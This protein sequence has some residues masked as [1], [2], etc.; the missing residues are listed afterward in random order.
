MTKRLKEHQ[1]QNTFNSNETPMF[2]GK[3]P[4]TDWNTLE[5]QFYDNFP[6]ITKKI[7][8]IKTIEDVNEKLFKL[9]KSTQDSTNKP[10]EIIDLTLDDHLKQTTATSSSEVLEEPLF[11]YSDI[12]P[13]SPAWYYA[14]TKSRRGNVPIYGSSSLGNLLGLWT[15]YGRELF[16]K[17]YY[18]EPYCLQSG[19][20]DNKSFVDALFPKSAE[21]KEPTPERTQVNFD[22]GH[23]KEPNA[24]LNALMHFQNFTYE[25]CGSYIYSKPENLFDVFVTPDGIFIDN[26]TGLRF[27]FEAKAP[28]PFV[29]DSKTGLYN[30]RKRVPFKKRPFYYLQQLYIQKAAVGVSSGMFSSHTNDG[31]VSIYSLADQKYVDI[32]C[33]CIN[34]AVQTYVIDKKDIPMVGNVYKGCKYYDKF[35][36]MTRKLEIGKDAVTVCHP[37]LIKR[38]CKKDS[39]LFLDELEGKIGEFEITTESKEEKEGLDNSKK[40]QVVEKRKVSSLY[41]ESNVVEENITHLSIFDE[42]MS[43]EISKSTENE[44]VSKKQKNMSTEEYE[45]MIDIHFGNGSFPL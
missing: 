3:K 24:T 16:G 39:R 27:T 40:D 38:F 7:F 41:T 13:Y 29:F 6:R 17:D 37:N 23:A 19:H 10:I 4:N 22:W 8:T 44:I 30:Y 42:I 36:E 32:F 33:K 21:E 31:S 45:K 43:K 15:K 9:E 18:K 35:I 25:T 14:R 34:W 1:S 11:D 28:C 5:P 2:S 20:S 12:E 26:I